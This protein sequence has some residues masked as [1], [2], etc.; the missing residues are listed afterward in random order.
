MHRGTFLGFQA[1]SP[2]YAADGALSPG[3]ARA[4]CGRRACAAVRSARARARAL[5]RALA[6]R[7]A[8]SA[9]PRSVLP[10]VHV[11]HASEHARPQSAVPRRPSL[12]TPRLRRGSGWQRAGSWREREHRRR[13]V[14][15]AAEALHARPPVDAARWPSA[16]ARL[17]RQLHAALVAHH[18]RAVLAHLRRAR[19]PAAARRALAAASGTRDRLQR[20]RH[21]RRRRRQHGARQLHGRSRRVRERKRARNC[22]AYRLRLRAGAG[23]AVHAWPLRRRIVC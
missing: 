8:P 12:Q 4:R 18:Q 22:C 13:V 10:R 21:A 9:P 2:V 5:L 19:V 11:S 6:A 3:A 15:A 17:A 7:A 23:R 16:R 14:V 20:L 1:C